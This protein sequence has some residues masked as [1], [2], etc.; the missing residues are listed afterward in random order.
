M[1]IG[2]LTSRYSIKADGADIWDKKLQVWDV[3]RPGTPPRLDL[4]LV[5]N[6]FAM[7]IILGVAIAATLTWRLRKANA[8]LDRILRDEWTAESEPE[9]LPASHDR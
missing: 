4:T 2:E 6:M 1:L 9:A 5:V 7:W 3:T 8:T